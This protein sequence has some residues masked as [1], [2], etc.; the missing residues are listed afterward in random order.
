MS[1]LFRSE[2][3][4]VSVVI[5]TRGRPELLRRSIASALAQTCEQLE[6]IVVLD[7]EDEATRE[8]VEAVENPRVRLLT[9]VTPVGGSEARNA[10]VRAA[11]GRYVALL[12]DDDEWLPHKIA[13]QLALADACSS[14]ER[15]VVTQ[16]LY[17][18]EE[19]ADEVWPGHLPGRGEPLSEFLFSSRGGFQTSTYLC[20]RELLLRVP[21][22]IGLVKHQDWDWFLR[23][24]VLP[25]FKLLVVPE[26]LSIYWVPTR[27]RHSV[28][29]KIDWRF[30]QAWAESMLSL[31]TA[32]AYSMF[33]LK[34]CV[35]GAAMQKEGANG[36][37]FLLREII[38]RGRPTPMI[39]A[40]FVAAVLVPDTLR[41][42]L[43][44]GLEAFR[45]LRIGFAAHGRFRRVKAPIPR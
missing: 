6:V 43:R 44:Y 33:I 15:V 31:M 37:W 16:Y 5:P 22:R 19:H 3:P 40:E 14:L 13:K 21:F 2:T 28:S 12:D 20:P 38:V 26:P 32:K 29:G 25:N 30:S 4:D 8:V 41:L 39:L 27:T 23:L 42:R 7:G 17:R 36:L 35:R 9:F 11:K 34:I 10:G 18:T 24:A 1:G 45:R